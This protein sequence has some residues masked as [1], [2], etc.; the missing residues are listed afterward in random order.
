MLIAGYI[1]YAIFYVA[2]GSLTEHGIA[3]Y[4]FFGFYGL[5]LASTEGVEKALVADLA[6]EGLQGAAFG[7]FNMTAGVMLLPASIL[8]GW[9]YQSI[10]L[11]AAFMFSGTCAMIAA[12]LLL[13]WIK[14]PTQASLAVEKF[15]RVLI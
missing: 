14:T 13:M 5:F 6:P 2:M 10:S 8:F 4:M 12:T 9:L 7:L 15:D 3:L 1:A 11:W